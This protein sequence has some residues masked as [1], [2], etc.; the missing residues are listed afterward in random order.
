MERSEVGCYAD[1]RGKESD[2]YIYIQGRMVEPSLDL[3]TT[4]RPL[5]FA[6]AV[7]VRKVFLQKKFV[8]YQKK[9]IL[10]FPNDLIQLSTYHDTMC[11]GR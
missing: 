8:L 1:K 5:C 10:L 11:S 6:H 9:F 7:L 3:R 4:R 2:T